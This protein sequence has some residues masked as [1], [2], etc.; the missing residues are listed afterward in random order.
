[1]II[2]GDAIAEVD[3]IEATEADIDDGDEDEATNDIEEID[4]KKGR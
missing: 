2:E 1:M 4:D 3:E